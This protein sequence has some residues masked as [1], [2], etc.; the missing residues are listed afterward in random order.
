MRHKALYIAT[1][2]FF[3]LVNTAY[4]WDSDLGAFSMLTFLLICLYF[5]ILLSYLIAQLFFLGI[6]KTNKKPR[7][8]LI[9]FMAV[10]LGLSAAYSG[11]IIPFNKLESKPLLIAQAEGAANCMTTLTLR[12]NKTFV[13][14]TVCFGTSKTTGNYYITG[15]TIYFSNISPGRGNSPNY[16]FGVITQLQSPNAS[17]ESVLIRYESAIDTIGQT[18]WI[19]QNALNDGEK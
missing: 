10:I 18:L 19:T 15:D 3:I 16:A 11:G 12:A 13:E 9:L 8:I 6:E 17:S 14:S 4:Y 2:I 7:I 5:I 1:T